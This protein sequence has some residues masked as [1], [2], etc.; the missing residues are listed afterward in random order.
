MVQ[1]SRFLQVS[2]GRHQSVTIRQ[3]EA[4]L[5]RHLLV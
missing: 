2:L 5:R 4:A 3:P 1:M